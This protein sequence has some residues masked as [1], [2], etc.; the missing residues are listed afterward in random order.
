[1][2]NPPAPRHDPFNWDIGNAGRKVT[3]RR[4][5]VGRLHSGII[6][7]IRRAKLRKHPSFSLSGPTV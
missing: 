7:R 4:Y 1:M 2:T 5:F 3:W 6:A